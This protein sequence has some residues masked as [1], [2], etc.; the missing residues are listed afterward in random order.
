MNSGMPSKKSKPQLP[1][2]TMREHI[3]RYQMVDRI[4]NSPSDGSLRV[5]LPPKPTGPD[6]RMEN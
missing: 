2:R 4:L 1:K 5:P 3:Q 6:M